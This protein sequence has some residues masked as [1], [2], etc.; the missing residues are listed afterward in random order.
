[1]ESK[2]FF[3]VAKDKLSYDFDVITK[4]LWDG[5]L[6]KGVLQ[7]ATNAIRAL[8][9]ELILDK[10]Y[11]PGKLAVYPVIVVHDSLYDTPALNY[12]VNEW[13][14]QALAELLAKPENSVLDIS[15][16]RPLTLVDIDT[17]DLYRANFQKGELNLFRLLEGYQRLVDFKKLPEPPDAH[18][19]NAITPFA[20]YMEKEAAKRG[21]T[22]NLKLIQDVYQKSGYVD[23]D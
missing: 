10:D 16:I 14:Q 2:D 15:S 21:V 7:S 13:F 6:G 19:Q 12:W 18:Y 3:M 5:R 22:I 17:L 4:G 9:Q 1:M 23:G 8:K 11:D 20:L